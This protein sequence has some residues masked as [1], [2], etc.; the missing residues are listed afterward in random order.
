MRRR[1]LAIIAA[2]VALSTSLTPSA[3][4]EVVWAGECIVNLNFYLMDN[5]GIGAKGVDFSFD[6]GGTCVSLLTGETVT[7][8]FTGIWGDGFAPVW[9]CEAV[10]ADASY[11]QMWDPAPGGV[12]GGMKLVGNNGAYT[13]VAEAPAFHAVAELTLVPPAPAVSCTKDAVTQV[14]MIGTMQFLDP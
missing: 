10:V 3:H 14:Q 9:S 6:G 8:S 12:Q 7:Q 4:A 5:T 11:N 2:L 13:L 1:I